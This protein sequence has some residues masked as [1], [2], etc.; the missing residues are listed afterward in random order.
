VIGDIR[1]VNPSVS[2]GYNSSMEFAAS[3]D[4]VFLDFGTR[5]VLDD[6]S[7][8][9]PRGVLTAIIGPN[10]CG[11]ST[12]ARMLCGFLFPTCG[13]I[14][15]LGHR[16]GEVNVHALRERVKLVQPTMLHEPDPRMDVRDV[17]LTGAFGT[18]D[19]HDE[20]DDAM[21]VRADGLISTLRLQRVAGSS[22]HTCSS[23]E[24][25][26]A[27][28]A[29]ALMSRPELLI[30]DE[31][32][33]GLDLP[34]REQMLAT[35]DAILATPAAPAILLVTHH[36][37]EL[38]PTTSH[39]VVMAVARVLASG[40]PNVV[41]TSQVLSDAFEFPIAVTRT[42]EGRYFGHARAVALE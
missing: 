42:E 30:L 8:A 17:I 32:T 25:M 15:I 3:L 12:I 38:P 41:L 11:K 19:L 36:L 2:V 22:F 13:T 21:Q 14:T 18:I 31:P 10:G 23:G 34:M 39:V 20:P 7:L 40:P 28:I 35:L 6:V 37:E 9:I 16:L 5:R 29:R 1:D 24:R 26:R 33:A 27:Q 4:H